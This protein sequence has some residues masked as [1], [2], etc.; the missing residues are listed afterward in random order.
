MDNLLPET[1]K[2]MSEIREQ[3]RGLLLSALKPAETRVVS[4]SFL[5][6]HFCLPLASTTVLQPM[7]R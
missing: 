3:T 5:A 6:I 2:G 4:R 1:H 7:S